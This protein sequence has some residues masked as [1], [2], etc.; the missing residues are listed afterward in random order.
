MIG[1]RITE[2]NAADDDTDDEEDEDDDVAFHCVAMEAWNVTLNLTENTPLELGVM[3]SLTKGS[4]RKNSICMSL[5]TNGF[6]LPSTSRSTLILYSC[7]SK[8]VKVKS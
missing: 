6:H 3:V 4:M 7:R 2:N 1:C 8:G 5:A